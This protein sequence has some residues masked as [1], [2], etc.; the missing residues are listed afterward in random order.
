MP[1][2]EPAKGLNYGSEL[3][4]LWDA[5]QYKYSICANL[6]LDLVPMFTETKLKAPRVD[7]WMSHG[8]VGGIKFAN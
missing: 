3:N 2:R 8:G 1:A 5:I 7:Y 4:T 6:V